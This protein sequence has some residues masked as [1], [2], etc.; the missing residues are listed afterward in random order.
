[1]NT[2]NTGIIR[3]IDDLGRIVI[4]RELRRK[5]KI[6]EGDPLEFYVTDD[7]VLIKKYSFS[8]QITEELNGAV[9]SLRGSFPEMR[10]VALDEYGGNI[11][12]GT[13]LPAGAMQ[14]ASDAREHRRTE[15]NTT[16]TETIVVVPIVASGEVHGMLM[17][18][19]RDED[20]DNTIQCVT[21]TIEAICRYI[22]YLIEK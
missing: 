13:S 11:K 17:A 4:P 22:K 21:K 6:H 5:L 18:M 1:M 9:A 15:T 20:K 19:S 3:R 14:T 16:D 10:F 2:K 8:K 12:P 7:G